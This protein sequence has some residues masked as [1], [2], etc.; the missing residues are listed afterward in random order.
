MRRTHVV[1]ILLMLSQFACVGPGHGP[2]PGPGPGN[3]AAGPAW[4][5]LPVFESA[6][7]LA[8][9]PS[10]DDDDEEED[11][12]G[13]VGVGWT[14]LMYI[15]NRVLD[16]FD[17]VRAR[18][19]L[20]PGIAIGARAT[21]YADV[22]VGTYATVYI[23]LP[24]PRGRTLPRLPF[25]LESK[26]GAELSVADVTLEAGLGPDYGMTE[27]GFGFQLFLIGLDVGI[28]PFEIGDFAAGLLT[29]DP[30]DDDF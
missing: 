25:G 9:T 8:G 1:L 21:E 11:S 12:I 14:I 28:D 3:G 22:F 6:E 17:I 23:G 16:L 13:P 24:G 18:L 5:G 4:S 20:G 2:G 10:W 27:I 15:P 7:S 29:F 26:S 30:M 19:R